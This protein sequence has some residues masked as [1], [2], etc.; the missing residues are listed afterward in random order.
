MRQIAAALDAAHGAKLIHRDVKPANIVLADDDF[1]CLLD[2]GLANAAN[3]AKLTSTGVNRIVR[4][5]RHGGAGAAATSVHDLDS[6]HAKRLVR[7]LK[8]TGQ[9]EA[10]RRSRVDLCGCA[11]RRRVQG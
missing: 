9:G 8:V 1:A 2:F 3:E 11:L 6:R 4:I 10:T 5:S 7:E